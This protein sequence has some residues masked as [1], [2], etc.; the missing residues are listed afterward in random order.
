MCYAT[1]W[2]RIFC[3]FI[4]T[5]FP[6]M[7]PCDILNNFLGCKLR[8]S[9]FRQLAGAVMSPGQATAPKNHCAFGCFCMLPLPTKLTT[10]R[11]SA[12]GSGYEPD[13]SSM[14]VSS[15]TFKVSS[16][17]LHWLPKTELL[18]CGMKSE[19]IVQLGTGFLLLQYESYRSIH[20]SASMF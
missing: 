19:C 11:I 1:L 8:A 4:W 6:V 7:L 18:G 3:I 15:E 14:K 20:G 9:E 10:G 13:L 16:D 5:S 17:C 2:Y 12:F